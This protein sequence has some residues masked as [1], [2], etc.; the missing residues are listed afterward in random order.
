[1][2]DDVDALVG[3]FPGLVEV[4][5]DLGGAPLDG[6]IDVLAQGRRGAVVT[7]VPQRVDERL[8]HE[9]GHRL[10]VLEDAVQDGAAAAGRGAGPLRSELL[11]SR[12]QSVRRLGYGSG[13]AVGGVVRVGHGRDPL[14]L[15]LSPCDGR[16]I[17]RAA[18]AALHLSC[19][20]GSTEVARPS[21]NDWIR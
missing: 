21:N 1:Q 2:N 3:L 9:H 16:G 15:W 18:V 8:A 19:A 11:L 17:V 4:D 6:V 10:A 12:G 14:G 7:E 13:G 5:A 20:P